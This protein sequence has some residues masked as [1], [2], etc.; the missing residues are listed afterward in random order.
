MSYSPGKR[1][2]QRVANLLARITALGKDPEN[3]V[4]DIARRLGC[5]HVTV[6][7]Y[8]REAGTYRPAPNSIERKATP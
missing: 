1:D 4:A 2:P 7:K 3:S 6:R 8:L 5:S